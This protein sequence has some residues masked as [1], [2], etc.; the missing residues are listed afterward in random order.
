[1]FSLHSSKDFLL[2]LFSVCAL[3]SSINSQPTYNYHFCF[4]QSNETFNA[5][6]QS[7]L[8][9]LLE[10]LSSKASQNYSFYN[11]SESASCSDSSPDGEEATV[12][13]ASPKSKTMSSAKVINYKTRLKRNSVISH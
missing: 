9:V 3:S 1:M 11:E 6:Y 2:I 5:Y 8:T 13:T 12:P 10:F 7:N 4:D